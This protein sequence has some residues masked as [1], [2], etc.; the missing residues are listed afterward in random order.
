M[1]GQMDGLGSVWVSLASWVSPAHVQGVVILGLL[2][3][4]HVIVVRSVIR[5]MDG[6][7]RVTATHERRVR[8]PASMQPRV[9]SANTKDKGSASRTSG[10]SRGTSAALRLRQHA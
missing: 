9:K 5:P 2:F 7:V 8:A 6:P 4:L 3:I 10:R 1:F